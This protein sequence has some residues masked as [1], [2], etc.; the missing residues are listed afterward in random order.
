MWFFKSILHSEKTRKNNVA[1]ASEEHR[2]IDDTNVKSCAQIISIATIKSFFSKKIFS[3]FLSTKILC[4]KIDNYIVQKFLNKRSSSQ[5]LK[6]ITFL[7]IARWRSVNVLQMI[8]N[9]KINNTLTILRYR[10]SEKKS[11]KRLRQ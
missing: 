7:L 5:K 8:N 11:R 4:L 9:Q 2:Y 3:S 1:S 6:T 10:S